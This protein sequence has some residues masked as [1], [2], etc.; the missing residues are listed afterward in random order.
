MSWLLLSEYRAQESNLQRGTL[1]YSNPLGMC[2]QNSPKNAIY[3]VRT[4]QALPSDMEET[5]T[6]TA[7]E[8]LEFD[9]T[10]EVAKH[11]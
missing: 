5:P 10:G 1:E 9:G 11:G 8:K 3:L 2:V 6:Q 7:L 4:P